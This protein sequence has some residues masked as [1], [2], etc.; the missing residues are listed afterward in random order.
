MADPI[1]SRI[2]VAVAKDLKKIY[3]LFACLFQVHI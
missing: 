3:F 1:G 2:T